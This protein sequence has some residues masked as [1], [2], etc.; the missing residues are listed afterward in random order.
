[1]QKNSKC[2]WFSK[3]FYGKFL[4]PVAVLA[5]TNG[6]AQSE[7]KI[8]SSVDTTSIRIGEQILFSVSVETD[9]T[10]LVIFPEDQTFSPLETVEAFKTDTTIMESRMLL[11]KTYALTQFDSGVYLLPT[12]RI[13]INGQGFFT[14]SLLV[15]VANVPVDTTVQKLYEI[16]PLMEVPGRSGAWIRWAIWIVVLFL[17]FGGIY[18]WFFVRKKKLTVE[19]E[20][21]LLPPFERA[22]RDLKRLES[23]RYL[24]QDEFKQ[25]YSELTGI[26]RA[27]LEE[28]VHVSAL[29]STTGQ[30]MDTLELLRDSGQLNLEPETLK[31]FQR[32]LETADL[33]KFA[34]SKP[35]IQTAEQDRKEVEAIVIKTREAIPEPTEEE[36]LEMEETRTALKA[37]K[38]RKRIW[39]AAASLTILL[40][41]SA[42]ISISYFGLKQVKNSL[43]GSPTQTLLEGE[44]INSTYGFP[45]ITIETPE[46]LYRRELELPAEIKDSI[47]E[48][49]AFA[50]NNPK[51]KISIGLGIMV[52][53]NNQAEP[54][55]A[56][57]VENVLAQMEASGARN[58]ITKQ[59]E[60]T[61]ASG[62][63]GVKVFGTARLPVTG[64]SAIIDGEYNILLFGGKGFIQ[65]AVL[66]W[67]RGDIPSEAI[68]ARIL[69][70]IDV[71]TV[72]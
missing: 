22:M 59:E 33:V 29:E 39:V 69:Q 37:H 51:A 23:S 7:P 64:S 15:S 44:W 27:Y 26:V 34:K 40:L 18:Y 21:A 13:E 24:I 6:F 2:F 48:M 12:Q 42:G 3:S 4:F 62:V 56:G 36:L 50:Y 31:Q 10:A 52:F 46:V 9:T 55:F 70:S 53:K 28:E 49:S 57:S 20:E 14:D 45:P 61:T 41:I 38:R 58:I 19:E 66:S 54:D 11:L 67:E 30:L 71:K 25:Y 65:Q 8:S 16:K 17:L 63:K 1:M 43:F 72:L 68:I 35:E 60:F 5:F 32:I 47:L